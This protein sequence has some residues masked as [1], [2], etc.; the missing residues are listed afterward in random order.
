[1]TDSYPFTVSNNHVAPL[2]DKIKAAARPPKFT[3]EFLKKLGF[4]STND[5]ALIPLLRKLGFLTD[6]STPTPLYD[7]LKDP[8]DMPFVLGEQIRDLY[9]DLFSINTEINKADEADVKG[10]MARVTGKDSVSVARYYSTFKALV[11]LARF[12]QSDA[13]KP[14]QKKKEESPELPK[15]DNSKSGGAGHRLSPEFNYNIQIHLPAT[16][17]IS[18]YNAIFKSLRD[19]L[20]D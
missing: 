7:R 4:S 19:H 16:T 17:D 20:L 9:E 10:A 11:G 12:D 18:V 8:K 1:M 2:F 3:H 6:D 14:A 15:P 13:I 5:R